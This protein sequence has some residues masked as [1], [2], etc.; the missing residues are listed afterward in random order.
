MIANPAKWNVNSSSSNFRLIGDP[1]G[2]KL[3]EE[4]FH[5]TQ[6]AIGELYIMGCFRIFGAIGSYFEGS[7]SPER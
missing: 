5:G 1:M 4:T 2:I 6:I 7:G 3:L